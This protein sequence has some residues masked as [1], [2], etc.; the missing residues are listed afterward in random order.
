MDKLIITIGNPNGV[1]PEIVFKSLKFFFQDLKNFSIILEK[2]IYN[3]FFKDLKG[4]DYIFVNSEELK[5]FNYQPGEKNEL[6]G[7]ASYLFLEEAT[8]ILRSGYAKGVV[9]APISK[10]LIVKA[11]IKDFIDHTTYFGKKFNS[12]TFMLFY[13]EKLKVILSTIH[14]PLKEVSKKLTPRILEDTIREGINFC[15]KVIDNDFRIAVCG[16]N[17]H[18]G[19]NGLIG[20]EEKK[21]IPV[22]ENFKNKGYKIFGP[23]PADTVFY[24]ALKGEFDLIVATYHDQGLA[25][26]KMLYFNQGVNVTLGLPFVRTS[27]DHG[28]AFDISGKNIADE[29]SMVYA[30][31]LALKLSNLS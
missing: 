28:C 2:E 19:E 6:S 23:L 31:K 5:S 27:P 3:I 11:G 29:S 21:F 12:Q 9:T 15:K 4:P 13:S 20:K 26:F 22:I 16:V 7:L 1:G 8:K 25:P 18:A 24:R 17:P 30:L 10:E 14:I